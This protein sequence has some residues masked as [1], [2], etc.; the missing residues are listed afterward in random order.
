[1][2]YLTPLCD[3]PKK[4]CSTQPEFIKPDPR[5]VCRMQIRDLFSGK[6][7]PRVNAKAPGSK[8]TRIGRNLLSAFG[9]RPVDLFGP[10]EWNRPSDNMG[11][12]RV[13]T[14]FGLVRC[15]LEF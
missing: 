2:F 12:F 5:K 15:W 6:V 8:M 14:I 3:V 13:F 10:R 9:F 7:R 11:R 1:M 4:V